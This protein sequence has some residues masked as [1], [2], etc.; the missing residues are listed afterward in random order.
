MALLVG[1]ASCPSLTGET[2]V[3]PTRGHAV[4]SVSPAKA[5]A[6]SSR[7]VPR[8]RLGTPVFR[9]LPGR[10]P[11]NPPCPP[12]SKGG[13]FGPDHRGIFIVRCDYRSW[14]FVGET[15]YAVSFSFTG[16]CLG[17]PAFRALPGLGGTGVSARHISFSFPGSCLGMRVPGLLPGP[18][19]G[20]RHL[21]ARPLRKSSPGGG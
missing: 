5:G 9:A 7:L 4:P 13:N 8:L 19:T 10:F 11:E 6:Q 3:P 14:R 15:V 1:R 17:I 21:Y 16:L 12:F 2:P 20:L 18:V